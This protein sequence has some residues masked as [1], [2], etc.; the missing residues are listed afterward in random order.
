MATLNPLDGEIALLEQQIKAL[1]DQAGALEASA[2]AYY[3]NGQRTND[4]L[5]RAQENALGD[6]RRAEAAAVREQ[7]ERL[8]RDLAKLREKRD[9]IDAAA[10]EAIAAGKDPVTA[11]QGEVAKRQMMQVLTYVVGGVVVVLV[12]A[13]AIKMLRSLKK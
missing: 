8:E 3:A 4:P 13:F 6:Q 2:N 12:V 5:Q 10:Q 9:A 7:I 1:R 11:Y